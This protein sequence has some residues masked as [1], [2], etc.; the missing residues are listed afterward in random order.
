MRKNLK[1][2]LLASAMLAVVLVPDWCIAQENEAVN[3]AASGEVIEGLP[4]LTS[5]GSGDGG[6]DKLVD[7]NLASSAASTSDS[8][9]LTDAALQLAYAEKILLRPHGIFSASTLFQLAIRAAV[10]QGDQETLGRLV[11]GAKQYEL[12]EIAKEAEVAKESISATR[13][14]DTAEKEQ[15]EKL[16]KLIA[17]L[18]DEEKFQFFVSQNLVAIAF[19]NPEEL[20]NARAS[21]VENQE[22]ARAA[23]DYLLADV[24]GRIKK[25]E[26][27]PQDEREALVELASISRQG[28][29]IARSPSEVGTKQ[30][31]H[32]TT[33]KFEIYENGQIRIWHWS[34]AGGYYAGT[35]KTRWDLSIYERGKLL[36]G[37][38]ADQSV[39]NWPPKKE[40]VVRRDG[41][42]WQ[43]PREVADKIRTGR[44]IAQ[45]RV[46]F[47]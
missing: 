22:L 20:K 15:L 23:K 43:I 3:T 36:H 47:L 12:D 35:V 33:G 45:L 28:R 8:V 24:D 26:S 11:K 34:K 27:L 7:W 9:G 13:S 19:D 10:N 5:I 17:E 30:G 14:G 2:L 39:T 32:H 1:N 40:S 41:E 46:Y 25:F 42:Y 21:L 37:V 31:S 6:F 16:E 44:A 29:I 4:I 38:H 18:S